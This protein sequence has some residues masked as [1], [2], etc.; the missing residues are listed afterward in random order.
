MLN[1]QNKI[2]YFQTPKASIKLYALLNDMDHG[3]GLLLSS[4]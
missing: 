2:K 1:I 3:P 4:A